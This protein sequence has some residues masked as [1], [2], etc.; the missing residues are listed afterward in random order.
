MCCLY[1][2]RCTND[3]TAELQ[4]IRYNQDGALT[5]LDPAFARSQANNWLCRQLYNGLL[6]LDDSLHVV[7]DL[8]T[9]W[10]VSEDGLVYTFLL[11]KEVSF[12]KNACFHKKDS[13]RAF[14]ASDVKY[15]FERL[16]SPDVNSPGSWVFKGRV[17]SLQPFA[18]PNDS[19][20]VLRLGQPFRPL[21]QLL[22]MPY[23][24]VVPK[25]AVDFYGQK[26]RSNAV[27]TGAYRLGRK[28]SNSLP[29]PRRI[30][31]PNIRCAS[32]L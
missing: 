2:W 14:I 15:S 6:R 1:G 13:T 22:T 12:H 10:T 19:T 23:C 30:A 5:S 29:F 20:F 32:R 25:E 17:D 21:L 11:K 18:A 28:G 27:G 16:L 8:A 9:K 31:K 7:S 24:S 26:F 4:T 3:K